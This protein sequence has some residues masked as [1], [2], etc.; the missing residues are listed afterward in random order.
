MSEYLTEFEGYFADKNIKYLGLLAHK[1]RGAAIT[2]GALKL[3]AAT[4]NLEHSAEIKKI[5]IED[6]EESYKK[7][8]AEIIEV[9]KVL[10]KIGY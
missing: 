3:A 10:K 7:V 6:I 5:T 4:E 1:L 8:C 9:S 2:T